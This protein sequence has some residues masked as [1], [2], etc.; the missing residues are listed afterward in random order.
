[1]KLALDF[2][3]LLLFIG[4]LLGFGIITATWVL[5]ITTTL[6]TLID[7]LINK[8]V[9][10]MRLF[11][12]IA[13]VLF[14]GLTLA[15]R[16]PR[17][18]MFK[19]TAINFLLAIAFLV[20]SWWR[21]EPLTETLFGSQILMP[22]PR[23]WQ[24][25]YYWIG[26]FIVGGLINLVMTLRYIAAEGPLLAAVPNALEIMGESFECTLLDSNV[27]ALCEAAANAEAQWGLV[28]SFGLMGLTLIFVVLQ[29]I[30][31]SKYG[32]ANETEET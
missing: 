2:L 8:K 3:P 30:F 28:K 24:L 12:W 11:T 15:T 21:K 13:V 25:T 1:M 7:Y 26:F 16:D 9:E 17:F 20:V 6:A 10:K 5:V 22:R 29:V 4:A 23:W 32:Q 27:L 31:M 18:V 14:G 19:T